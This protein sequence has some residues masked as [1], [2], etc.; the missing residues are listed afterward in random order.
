MTE[1][2]IKDL[3]DDRLKGQDDQVYLRMQNDFLLKQNRY[4]RLAQKSYIL[5]KPEHKL[6]INEVDIFRKI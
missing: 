4:K 5:Q 6:D 1:K 2:Q 3:N